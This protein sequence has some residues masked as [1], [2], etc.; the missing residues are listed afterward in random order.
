M[1]RYPAATWQPSPN[2]DAREGKVDL[3]VVHVAD[4]GPKVEHTVRHLCK[5]KQVDP[6]RSEYNPSPVSAHFV[7]GRAGEVFQLV[8]LDRAA[9]HC[10]GW[11]GRSVGIEHCCRTPGELRAW[12]SMSRDKRS[13]LLEPGASAALIGSLVDPGLLPTEQ[14]LRASAN[15]TAWLCKQLGLPADR[16]HVRPHCEC[17][18]TT[19]LDCG[20]DVSNHGVWPWDEYLAMVKE[21]LVA[22]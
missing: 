22:L 20:R 16:E 7:V 15:L 13:A 12:P 9:W 21:E 5:P 18:G 8:D 11:N 4:G 17:P 14:L 10:R 19:H 6:K 3:I 1:T 2:N